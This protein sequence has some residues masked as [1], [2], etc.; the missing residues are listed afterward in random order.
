MYN[1]G[2][3]S[4]EKMTQR[5]PFLELGTNEQLPRPDIKTMPCP[6]LIKSHL[7]Y[8]TTPK[9]ASKDAQ[10]KYIYIARN[11]K[12]VAVSYFHFVK[13]L[14]AYGNGYNGPWEY[15][16]KLFMEGNGKFV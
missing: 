3:I 9:S 15:F 5:V 1:E 8:N 4:N 16:L 12:D 13:T 14:S 6:R 11:P 2:V 10:C 7:S